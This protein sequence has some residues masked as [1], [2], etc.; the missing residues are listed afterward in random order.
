LLLGVWLL[1]LAGSE[2]RLA[3]SRPVFTSQPQSWLSAGQS[4]TFTA[5]ANE[6]VTFS[7]RA[8][9]DS[10][11]LDD[12]GQRQLVENTTPGSLT[13]NAGSIS[14]LPQQPWLGTSSVATLTVYFA[15]PFRS[16]PT[17]QPDR[18]CGQSAVFVVQADGNPTPTGYQWQFQP[19]GAPRG[20]TSRTVNF[21]GAA[22]RCSLSMA[23]PGLGRTVPA[24]P[25]T[26]QLRHKANRPT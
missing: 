11:Q 1:G 3:S 9:T 13:M 10:A 19:A 25:A 26:L 17:R 18:S 2:L 6:S 22:T 5:A 4:A 7:W 14:V 8:I 12:S 23:R 16:E 15:R 24:Y 21:S 20:A